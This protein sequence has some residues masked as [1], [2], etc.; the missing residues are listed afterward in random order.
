M[1][2]L[3]TSALHATQPSRT[4]S[5][6]LDARQA[7]TTIYKTVPGVYGSESNGTKPGIVAGIVIGVAAAFLLVIC[8]V[9]CWVNREY[10]AEARAAAAAAADAADANL[11]AKVSDSVSVM[12]MPAPLGLHSTRSSSAHARTGSHMPLHGNSQRH[13]RSAEQARA[14]AHKPSRLSHDSGVMRQSASISRHNHG[15]HLQSHANSAPT[16]RPF[17]VETETSTSSAT[18]GSTSSDV[19]VEQLE[20]QQRSLTRKPVPR[21]VTDMV[22]HRAELDGNQG[23]DLDDYE[24]ISHTHGNRLSRLM[25]SRRNPSRQSEYSNMSVDPDIYEARTSTGRRWSR[26]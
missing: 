11:E 24:E 20:R 14:H 15:H 26:I 1:P 12:S 23:R 3:P 25:G 19:F 22:A 16:P 18:L 17:I 2:I 5:R 9:Y 21:Q 8:S 4:V 7:T 10:A 13:R 6:L